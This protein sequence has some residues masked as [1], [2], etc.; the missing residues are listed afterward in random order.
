MEASQEL[1]SRNLRERGTRVL[2]GGVNSPVRA[3]AA[4]PGKAPIIAGGKGSRVTDIDGN[5]YTD[6]ILGY[7]GHLLGH[8]PAG[9]LD[10]IRSEMDQSWSF[11]CTTESEIVLGEQIVDSIPSVDMVRFV[12]SGT[13]ATMTAL[14]LARGITNRTLIVK[15]DGGY[16]GHS[17]AL[18]AQAGSGVA[19]LALPGARGV[20]P[21]S[22]RDTLVV[23]YNDPDAM[24][25][26]FAH[27]GEH[28]AAVIIEP[29]AGNIG[30]IP[31]EPGYLQYL[32]A[33]TKEYGALLIADE[34]MTGYRAA[35]GSVTLA[36]GGSFDLICLGKII[37][38]GFPVGAVAGRA[39]LMEQLAPLGPVYQAGT[40]SGHRCAMAGGSAV[41]R[42]LTE[43]EP[44]DALQEMTGHLVTEGSAILARKGI[45]SYGTHAGGMCS[46]FFGI[47]EA[48]SYSEV[49]QADTALFGSYHAHMF[50]NGILLPP[51]QF[52]AVFVSSAHTLDDIDRYLSILDA[53]E[54]SHAEG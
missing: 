1:R 22:V 51:S 54:P 9:V 23:P 31:P 39:S 35:Y 25:N 45:P 6:Y 41:L 7:G 49:Q 43:T 4:V 42:S 40:M 26:V 38:A 13:E 19:T 12:N 34:V 27:H 52:E 17:D 3:F 24:S 33:V 5:T 28:I 18:L 10:A 50:N 44:Y 15:C 11:G 14:R 29:V 46:I 32:R 21:N 53:W 36:R 48:H 30:C 8:A 47:E 20:T 16:H 2:V 37:G